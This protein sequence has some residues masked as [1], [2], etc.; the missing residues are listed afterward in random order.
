MTLSDNPLFQPYK[1]KTAKEKLMLAAL[2]T[3]GAV[4]LCALSAGAVVTAILAA[5]ATLCL[6]MKTQD[7]DVEE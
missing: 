5:G 4:T 2:G 1:G 7:I 3:S 6:A